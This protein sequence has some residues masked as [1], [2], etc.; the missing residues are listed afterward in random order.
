MSFVRTRRSLGA[1]S[2]HTVTIGNRRN[3]VSALVIISVFIRVLPI[4]S[5]VS[6]L[7]HFGYPSLSLVFI[8]V[9]MTVDRRNV[10]RRC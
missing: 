9:D 2:D 8:I 3:G 1:S 5:L 7:V 4:L 10:L 6:L